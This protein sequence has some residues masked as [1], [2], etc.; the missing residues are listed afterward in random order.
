MH[1]DFNCF[2]AEFEGNGGTF[3]IKMALFGEYGYGFSL[4]STLWKVRNDRTVNYERKKLYARWINLLKTNMSMHCV[5]GFIS[6]RA[7]NTLRPGYKNQS[8]RAV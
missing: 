2:A 7:V 8:F 1:S 5:W 3:F 4:S 6:Y